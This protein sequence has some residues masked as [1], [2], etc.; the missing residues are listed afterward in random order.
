MTNN[1]IEFEQ[2]IENS[3]NKNEKSKMK[4]RDIDCILNLDSKIISIRKNTSESSD[5][6]LLN[7]ETP[8]NSSLLL[9]NDS[10]M[11]KE[12]IDDLQMFRAL[13]SWNDFDELEVLGQGSYGKIYKVRER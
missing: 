12:N 13:P 8:N 3:A 11:S 9:I 1:F 6:F 10:I 4:K 2:I 7:E 5:L